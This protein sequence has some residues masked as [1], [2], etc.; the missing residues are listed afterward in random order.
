MKWQIMKDDHTILFN[1]RFDAMLHKNH[2]QLEF[3]MKQMAVVT[4]RRACELCAI[5]SSKNHS[6]SDDRWRDLPLFYEYFH[7][8]KGLA[9]ALAIKRDGLD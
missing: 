4:T 1:F 6:F 8:D 5:N 7:G 9:S 2:L 3:Y